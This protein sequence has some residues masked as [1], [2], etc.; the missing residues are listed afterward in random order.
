VQP[1]S[2]ISTRRSRD[3]LDRRTARF[4]GLAGFLFAASLPVILWHRAIV[5][6]AEDFRVELEYLLTGWLGYGLIAAGL[7]F[8]V[9]VL[10]SIGRDPDSRLYPRSRNALMGWGV[11][12][13]L[14]GLAL[15]VQ[16]AQIAAGPSGT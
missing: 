11:S 3:Q 15:A 8:F 16:V 4:V 13:Y 14:L 12:C 6:I 7:L 1:R 10:F 5:L 2:R 9:P